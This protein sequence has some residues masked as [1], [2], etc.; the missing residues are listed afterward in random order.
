MGAD[1][2]AH[3]L[4]TSVS[5]AMYLTSVDGAGNVR[6]G[7]SYGPFAGWTA[8]AIADAPDGSTRVLW[9]ANDGRFSISVHHG[10]AMGEVVRFAAI[11]GRAAADI[12][13]GNDG[14]ARVL[15]LGGD[16]T[17]EV[18]T[19]DALGSLANARTHANAGFRPRRIA[20]GPDGL[21]RLLWSDAAG[22]AR[23][24]LLDTANSAQSQPAS[25]RSALERR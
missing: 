9:R 7:P 13:V 18:A 25:S 3:L 12:T 20:A 19:V 1:G 2:K 6:L 10:L 22:S 17:A 24:S 15:L 14:N 23:V 4:W 21:T 16:G 8:L 11:P 5:G